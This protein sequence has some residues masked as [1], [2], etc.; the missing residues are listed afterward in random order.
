M[1]A[2][3]LPCTVPDAFFHWIKPD[4]VIEIRRDVLEEVDGPVLKHRR[5]RQDAPA[6]RAV[7]EIPRR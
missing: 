5:L 7:R 2:H 1:I 4:H 3:H 6:A